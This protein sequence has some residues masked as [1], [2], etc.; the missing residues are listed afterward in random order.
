MKRRTIAIC[1]SGYHSE[2]EAKIISEIIKN[3][4]QNNI[5]VLMFNSLMNKSDYPQNVDKNSNLVRGESEVFNLIN[6]QKIDGLV[7]FGNSIQ[8]EETVLEIQK[9]CKK[10]H[11][12]C[13]NINDPTHKL[14]H[15]VTISNE[16]SMELIMEHLVKDHK[17][18]K[19]N[20]IGGFK[21]NKETSER[22]L[23]YKK[24]LT[25]YNIP[26]E[27]ERIAY[28]YFWMHAVE[29]TKE[30]LRHDRP[31]AIVCANDTMAIFVIDYLKN[32]GYKVPKDIIVTGFDGITDAFSYEPSLTTVRHRYEYAGKVTF[33][34]MMK[35]MD[36]I[37]N[38]KD[39][40]IKSELI[41]QESCG[42]KVR[43]KRVY[44]FIGNK[45]E[46]QNAFKSF[47]K[48][49]IRSDIHFSDEEDIDVLFDHISTPLA[50]FEMNSFS[51]CIDATLDSKNN[52][53]LSTKSDKYGIPQKVVNVVP[54]YTS[55]ASKEEFASKEM[56]NGDF[57]EDN[58]PCFRIFTC[59]Y[60]K[61][62]CLGYVAY[63][64]GDYSDFESGSFMLWVYNSAEKIGS[65]CLKKELEMLNLKDH[66]TGLY[67]R[68]GMEKYFSRMYKEV[69]PNN[70]YISVICA[71]IDYLKT[72]NDRFGHEG[73]DNAI[74]HIAA[75]LESVFSKYGICVRTGGDEFCVVIHSPR[76]LNVDT[77]IKKVTTKLDEYNRKKEVNYT[78]M[79]SCGYNTLY[80][81]DFTSFEE[82]QKH[83]D[84][85]LYEVKAQHHH[86]K[87]KLSLE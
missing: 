4:K 64:P 48:Q 34:M 3:S 63:E 71:D 9:K 57:L 38:V 2:S 22:L 39:E 75:A 84:Q 16:D 61:N 76:K 1:E 79:C 55:Y 35:L 37:T 45:Y 50:F 47:T 40:A 54:F 82:M 59:M 14:E 74:V 53:F 43:D 80:S 81:K 52:Y 7:I 20:F 58:E 10:N 72:I 12:P 33:E 51:Y 87:T 18:T 13:I 5:N 85:K 44:D 25:K 28:G 21:D 11:I 70:E 78:V 49:M 41:L 26:I 60:Y 23:A 36:G 31:Q 67:N 62:K 69:I 27:E 83:A 19:I 86:P 30:F 42:C 77:L 73:G 66:L 46:R 15:N 68:R 6:Y 17:L 32:E 29:C 65:F 56:L 24:V 8:R